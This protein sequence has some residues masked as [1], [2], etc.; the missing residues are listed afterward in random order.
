M[1]QIA[2]NR[3]RNFDETQFSLAHCIE[4][5]EIC[6][7]HLPFG[8]RPVIGVNTRGVINTDVD[9]TSVCSPFACNH[10]SE[11]Q[12]YGQPYLSGA[13]PHSHKNGFDDRVVTKLDS[14]MIDARP[15]SSTASGEEKPRFTADTHPYSQI[16]HS[17]EECWAKI[18][19]ICQFFDFAHA[20]KLESKSLN[21]FISQ[22]GRLRP[23]TQRAEMF[24]KDAFTLMLLKFA[25][26]PESF[27]RLMRFRNN[28]FRVLDLLDIYGGRVAEKKNTKGMEPGRI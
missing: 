1:K 12:C 23:G 11:S 15:S 21:D 18:G 8:S 19:N 25:A 7:V 5:Q 6:D 13:L 24:K 26:K 20:L 9:A 10:A 27:Q 2:I 28:H 4:G 17:I 16:E 14:L 3:R 22:N